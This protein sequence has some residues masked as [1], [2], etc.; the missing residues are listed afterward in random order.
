MLRNLAK[1]KEENIKLAERNASS[2]RW[3][4]MLFGI[5]MGMLLMS[6]LVRILP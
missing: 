1:E 5:L 3:G 2:N 6:M 4:Y